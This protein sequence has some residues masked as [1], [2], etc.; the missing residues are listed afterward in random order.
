MH[1]EFDPWLERL[2]DERSA[3]AFSQVS[4]RSDRYRDLEFTCYEQAREL[5]ELLGKDADS[6]HIYEESRSE[7]DRLEQAW[8]YRQGFADCAALLDW[9]S[10]AK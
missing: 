5:A 10:A 7:L 8:A 1:N 4:Q 3:A 2:A 9:L 6:L